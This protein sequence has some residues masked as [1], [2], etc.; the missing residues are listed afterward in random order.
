MPTG[1]TAGIENGKIKTFKDFALLCSRA[2][3][4][5]MRDEDLDTPYYPKTPSIYYKESLEEAKQQLEVTKNLTDEE[6]RITALDIMDD[7]C[8]RYKGYIDKADAFRKKLEAILVDAENY[9]PP[10]NKHIH[11]KEFMIQQLKS[12]I[13]H[14]GS[15]LLWASELLKVENPTLDVEAEKAKLIQESEEKLIRAQENYDNDIKLVK[16]HNKWY[17]DFVASL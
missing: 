5:H 6:V 15:P 17:D 2:Y 11:I 13:K 4:S 16:D 7:T 3:I 14:D 8:A 10:T 9:V 1:Y 12:T